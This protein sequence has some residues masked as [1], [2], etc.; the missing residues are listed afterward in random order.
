MSVLLVEGLLGIKPYSTP[1]T[2]ALPD[3]RVKEAPSFSRLGV[4]FVESQRKNQSKWP[5]LTL[6]Y[7]HVA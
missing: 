6:R 3:F 1:P 2:A 4:D 5:R 7:F